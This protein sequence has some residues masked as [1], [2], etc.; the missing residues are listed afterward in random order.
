M[1]SLTSMTKSIFARVASLLFNRPAQLFYGIEK[2]KN[3]CIP[4]IGQSSNQYQVQGQP[5][6]HKILS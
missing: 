3:Y 1:I 5:G 6:P 4:T 2:L